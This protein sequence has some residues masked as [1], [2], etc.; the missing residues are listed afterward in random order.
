MTKSIFKTL[1]DIIGLTL[2]SIPRRTVSDLIRLS[3]TLPKDMFA[4]LTP[5]F[6]LMVVTLM[7]YDD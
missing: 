3:L 5:K 2:F 6:L 7:N 4:Q 1:A